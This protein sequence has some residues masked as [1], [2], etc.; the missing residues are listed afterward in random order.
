MISGKLQNELN[1]QLNMEL[2][3]SYLYLAMS[4]HFLRE[5]LEGIAHWLYVQSL[6]E[7]GHAMRIFN[8]IN[9]QNGRIEL[10]AIAKPQSSWDSPLV[11]FKD[12]WAHEQKVTKAIGKL[13]DSAQAEKDHAT[14]AFLTWFVTEQVEEEASTLSIVEKLKIL[15]DV[16]GGFFMIDAELGKRKKD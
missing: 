16:P 13:M 3:S 14:E 7:T 15:Q 2:F 12:A 5:N 8:Y 1:D 6:E 9:R 10:T 11:A 4:A